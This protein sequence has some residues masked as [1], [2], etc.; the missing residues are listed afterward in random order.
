[1]IYYRLSALRQDSALVTILNGVILPVMPQITTAFALASYLQIANP[2]DQ[3]LRELIE[4]GF[5]ESGLSARDKMARFN[6]TRSGAAGLIADI[7]AAVALNN[8]LRASLVGPVK[9]S[10]PM[11]DL[12]A[13]LSS[14]LRVVTTTVL[15][16]SD[17][18]RY[19]AD[20]AVGQQVSPFLFM[21]LGEDGDKT[22]LLGHA[23]FLAGQG[24]RR[25]YGLFDAPNEVQMA[26]DIHLEMM[27]I[28]VELRIVG[29]AVAPDPAVVRQ[30]VEQGHAVLQ[31][32]GGLPAIDLQQILRSLDALTLPDARQ[33]ASDLRR[34]GADH[35]VLANSGQ[36]G[37][38]V[39]KD[40]FLNQFTD[41]A[42]GRR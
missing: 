19:M 30:A 24:I 22:K 2:S 32:M 11:I 35:V 42:R 17:L 36:F 39:L 7:D 37:P 18:D 8:R 12:L 23:K 16:Q 1:M 31:S 28:G 41:S 4:F 13:R 27:V 38:E 6:Q 20:S 5:K 33:L 25:M 14:C 34:A 29:F 26:R 21:A 9:V 40:L 15:P 3:L 10:D